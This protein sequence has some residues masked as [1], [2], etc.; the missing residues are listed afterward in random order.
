MNFDWGAGSPGEGVP[1]DSFSARWT[2]EVWVAGGAYRVF[3][4]VDDGARLWIDGQLLIDAWHIATG[5]T[6]VV[7]IDLADGIHTMKVEYFEE[8]LDA[9]IHLWAEK[10]TGSTSM[11]PQPDS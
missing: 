9:R 7:E 1:P 10:L 2:R 11:S 6:Y 8:F 5:E 3:L 4:E